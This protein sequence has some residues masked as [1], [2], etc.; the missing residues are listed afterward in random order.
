MT[1]L[2]FQAIIWIFLAI[3]TTV[4]F[5]AVLVHS[6]GTPHNQCLPGAIH[7]SICQLAGQNAPSAECVGPFP[8]CT[9]LRL[10]GVPAPFSELFRTLFSYLSTWYRHYRLVGIVEGAL[11]GRFV[12]PLPFIRNDSTANA[13]LPTADQT[14]ILLEKWFLN[15]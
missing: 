2:I 3:I 8:D 9:H 15:T 5:Y 6:L 10:K 1:I 12:G 7:L 14:R 13:D 4:P 11:S